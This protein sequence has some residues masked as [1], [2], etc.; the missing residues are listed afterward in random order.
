MSVTTPYRRI[1]EQQNQTLRS[2]AADNE[3]NIGISPYTVLYMYSHHTSKFMIANILRATIY[4]I[5]LK[6]FYLIL[7]ARCYYYICSIWKTGRHSPWENFPVLHSKEEESGVKLMQDS[8]R[9][10]TPEHC[11]TV[12]PT[13]LTLAILQ[14]FSLS[15]Q[16]D[17]ACPECTIACHIF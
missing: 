2:S 8:N 17:D 15:L 6:V 11:T 1:S 13:V 12:P 16:I 5:L 10:C 3:P 9:L 7:W 14:P 4:P